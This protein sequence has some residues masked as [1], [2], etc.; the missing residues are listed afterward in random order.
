MQALNLNLLPS[1]KTL[2]PKQFQYF[3]YKKVLTNALIHQITPS[4][5]NK[6]AFNLPVRRIVFIVLDNRGLPQRSLYLPTTYTSW[7]ARV[8][9]VYIQRR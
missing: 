4:L 9:A 2:C 1:N 8:M 6:A 3:L 7:R 5:L